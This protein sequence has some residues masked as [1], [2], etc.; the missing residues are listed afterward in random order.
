[1]D[2][3]TGGKWLIHGTKRRKDNQLQT[4]NSPVEHPCR[5]SKHD[6][7]ESEGDDPILKGNV[8]GRKHQ[9]DAHLQNQNYLV[10]ESLN[11]L[12]KIKVMA[13]KSQ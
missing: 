6:M 9:G 8:Q 1:M 3:H 2:Q 4:R 11:V 13:Q 5:M 10:S 7:K 12:F